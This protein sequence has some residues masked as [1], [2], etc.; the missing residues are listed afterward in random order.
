[1]GGD[2][3]GVGGSGDT[4][5]PVDYE[6]LGEYVERW[7]GGDRK[8]LWGFVGYVVRRWRSVG[9]EFQL[10]AIAIVAVLLAPACLRTLS[11]L[12]GSR[13]RENASHTVSNSGGANPLSE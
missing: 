5:T 8:A 4:A 2:S 3:S 12:R 7:A 9:R 6:R 10:G 1:V 11:R 13:E